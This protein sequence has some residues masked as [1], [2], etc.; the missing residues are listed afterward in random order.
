MFIFRFFMV[1]AKI[2]RIDRI[3]KAVAGII[4]II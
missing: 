4:I 3:S 1:I 2:N